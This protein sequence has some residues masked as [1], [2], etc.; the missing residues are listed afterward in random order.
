MI[1]WKAIKERDD[2]N[3]IFNVNLRNR[4]REPF[5]YTKFNEDIICSGEDI[6]MIYNSENQGWFHFSRETLTL[7]LES[8]NLVLHSI[9]SDDNIPSPRTLC[10]LK[11]LQHKVD[12]AVEIAKTRWSC[13]LAEKIYN[14]PFNP[15]GAWVSIRRLMGGATSHHTT[16]K[17]I[18]MRLPSGSLADKDEDN[19][20]VF[21]SHLKKALNNHKPID[22][23][24]INDI[25]LREVMGELDVPPLWTEFN[26][27]I[28]ELTNDKAPG[29]NGVPPNAFKSMSEE[30]MRHHFGFITEFWEEKVNFEEWHEGQVFPVPK[31]GDLYDP[32]KRRGLNLMDIGAKLFSSLICKQIFKIIEKHG[33]K[34]QFGS[35]LGVGC[36]D[37]TFTIKTI[38]HMRQNHNLPSYAAFVD[39]VKAFDNVNNDMMLKILEHYGAPQ[40]LCPAIS[41]MYHYL[42]IVLK[43]GKIEE[44]TSQT[45][46]VRQGECMAPVLFLF[47]VMAFTKTLEKQ[48]IKADLNM[49]NLR[50]HTHSPCDVGNITGHKKKSFE[51]GTLIALFCVLYVDNGLFKFEDI[52]QLTQGLTL[53]YHHFTSF[54]LE[55]HVGKGKKASKTEWV[56]FSPP[57]FWTDIQPSC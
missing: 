24:V 29:L 9:R 37:G 45:V 38:L 1:D 26:S 13:H 17:L 44:K 32:N 28:Q 20:I 34:Y 40:K 18:Q 5:N 21:A 33:V 22:K 4:P 15:K 46:G 48:W 14:M 53:I 11:T 51:Q 42:K 56:F 27:A 49:V 57:G 30:N 50:Q 10:H 47:I 8:Q 7:A 12:E 54:G 39:L 55:M 35:A 16:P 25:H 19:V 6:A 36:Q 31:S 43:I 23:I 52:D 2:V 41:R 3:K